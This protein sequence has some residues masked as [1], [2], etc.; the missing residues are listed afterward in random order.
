MRQFVTITLAEMQKAFSQKNPAGNGWVQGVAGRNEVVFDFAVS[1]KC[2]LRVWTSIRND[3]GLG[4]GN[5]DDAIRVSAFN[6]QNQRGLVKASYVQ[7]IATWEKNLR[8]RIHEVHQI[9]KDRIERGF[10]GSNWGN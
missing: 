9:A 10:D 2:T 1:P 6:P 8:S 5:G 3:N 7:R 4:R